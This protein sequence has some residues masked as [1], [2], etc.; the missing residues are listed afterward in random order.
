PDLVKM[1]ALYHSQVTFI[2]VDMTESDSRSAVIAFMKKVG[3]HYPVLLDSVGK[4]A[5]E[6]DVISIPTSFFI[7]SKGVIVDRVEG[8]L[9]QRTLQAELSQLVKISSESKASQQR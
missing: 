1:D 6:Y 9:S 3:I 5:K 2:G 7:N 4:V 8:A